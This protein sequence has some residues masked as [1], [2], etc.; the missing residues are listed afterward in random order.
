MLNTLVDLL[1]T[2][3]LAVTPH[4]TP[5]CEEQTNEQTA[6]ASTKLCQYVQ[7]EGSFIHEKTLYGFSLR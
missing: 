2:I 5:F 4:L 3:I 7:M 1:C 6:E